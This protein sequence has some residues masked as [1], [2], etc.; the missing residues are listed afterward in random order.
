[1]W[2]FGFSRETAPLH[3]PGSASSVWRGILR[4]S[5]QLRKRKAACA[6]LHLGATDGENF[7]FGRAGMSSLR[8]P[9][10]YTGRYRRSLRR[11]EDSRLSRPAFPASPDCSRSPKPTLRNRRMMAK[12]AAFADVS[13]SPI[14]RFVPVRKFPFLNSCAPPKTPEKRPCAPEDGIRKMASLT[15]RNRL[16]HDIVPDFR[17]RPAMEN[18]VRFSYASGL[19]NRRRH[20]SAPFTRHGTR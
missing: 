13:L 6:Q 3:R 15:A 2:V 16:F 20:E 4:S 9:D 12:L 14:H 10:A 19:V 18:R 1:M 5:R 17:D 11:S 7:R 8:R